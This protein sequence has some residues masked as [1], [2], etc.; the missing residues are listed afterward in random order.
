MRYSCA[1]RKPGYDPVALGTKLVELT[2]YTVQPMATE[3]PAGVSWHMV[4]EPRWSSAMCRLKL[5]RGLFR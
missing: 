1:V 3:P 5:R 2:W 4:I